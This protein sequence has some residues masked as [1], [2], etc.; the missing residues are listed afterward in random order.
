ME[1]ETNI[2]QL[3]RKIDAAC[4]RMNAGL[5]AVASI[6]AVAVVLTAIVRASEITTDLSANGTIPPA[7][8]GD[9]QS[10]TNPWTYY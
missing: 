2:A 7:A 9:N 8:I 10:M 1:N 6:L 3:L 5:S 4:A